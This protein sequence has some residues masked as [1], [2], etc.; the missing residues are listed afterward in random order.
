[1][2]L[3]HDRPRRLIYCLAPLVGVL[4][5]SSFLPSTATAQTSRPATDDPFALPPQTPAPSVPAPTTPGAEQ[6]GA[7]GNVPQPGTVPPPGGVP[8]PESRET[9]PP[10][11]QPEPATAPTTPAA[12][13]GQM[14]LPNPFQTPPQQPQP[15]PEQPRD[16]QPQGQQP[17]GQQPSPG[18]TTTEPPS[19]TPLQEA[20]KAG[21]DALGKNDPKGALVHFLDAMRIEPQE[22]TSY[23]GQGIAF[24]QLNQLDDAVRAFSTALN[25]PANI[26][27]DS[28]PKAETYLRRGIVW[29]YKGEYGIA[30]EDF[31]EAAGLLP[32]DPVPLL[33]K[34][35]ARSRQN[36]LLEAVNEYASAL[37]MNPRYAAA[38]VNRGLAYMALNEPLKAVHDFNQAVR[39]DPQD[40]ATYFKR[41]VALSRAGK[42]REAVDSYSEAIR[43]K[44]DYAE[45]FFNRGVVNRRL[46]E[47]QAAASDRAAAVKI[48]PQIEKQLTSAG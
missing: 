17:Q 31:D 37:D 21:F 39:N 25:M 14:P 24:R 42:L 43:I 44:P 9:T 38:F 4:F 22:P 28:D 19:Y 6:S 27:P 5:T 26:F 10:T 23:I 7:K 48:N 15:I 30:W 33:W 13:S 12:P 16:N 18:G 36:R 47:T 3:N 11:A 35:L 40:P 34:G 1:M 29:F 45:A 32:D 8:Q 2:S 46:G 20:L 41:G